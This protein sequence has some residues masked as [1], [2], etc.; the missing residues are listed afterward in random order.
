MSVTITARSTNDAEL[1]QL[2]TD[3]LGNSLQFSN[4]CLLDLTDDNGILWGETPYGQNWGCRFDDEYIVRIISWI[5]FW[6]QPRIETGEL[7]YVNS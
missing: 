4:G 3:N 1:T 7:I 5:Y 2:I 6:D